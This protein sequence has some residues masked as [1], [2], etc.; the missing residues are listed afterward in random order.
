MWIVPQYDGIFFFSGAS[1]SVYSKVVAAGF[2]NLS[3]DAGVS[4]PYWR[5]KDRRAPHNLMLDTKKAYK[6]A[7][8]RKH[9]VTA[10]LEPLAFDRR[11]AE[12]TVEIESIDIPFSQANRVKW[13]Y[14]EDSGRYLR[15]N[16]GAVHKDR[17]TGK[18]IAADNVVVVWAKYTPASRDKVRSVTYDIKLGGEGRATIFKR[19][20]R[21][22]VKWIATRNAPPRFENEDGEPVKLT[23]GTTWFQVIPLDGKVIME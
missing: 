6:E 23:P 1:G 8:K 12:T 21:H 5:A 7:K 22:D 14:D 18:Q 4:A 9:K 3:Q 17:A 20:E 10:E 2:P 11:S 16:N 15:W 13:K 19:G